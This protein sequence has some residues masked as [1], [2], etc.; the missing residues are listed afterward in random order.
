MRKNIDFECIWPIETFSAYGNY[1]LITYYLL[2]YCRAS[3]LLCVNSI[4]RQSNGF[5][6]ASKLLNKRVLH[7]VVAIIKLQSVFFNVSSTSVYKS[8]DPENYPR[9]VRID[10]FCKFVQWS[11][12]KW[13]VFIEFHCFDNSLIFYRFKTQKSPVWKAKTGFWKTEYFKRKTW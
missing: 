6:Y 9:T 5:H 2:T 8:F 13:L 4:G 7:L 1:L 3:L 10:F 12:D 11:T